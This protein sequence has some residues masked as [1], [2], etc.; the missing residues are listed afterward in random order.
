M[1]IEATYKVRLT[2]DNRQ[3]I[4]DE[5]KNAGVDFTYHSV[6]RYVHIYI[7]PN[8]CTTYL[9]V[10]TNFTEYPTVTTEKFIELIREHS[11]KLKREITGHVE[12]VP[13][14]QEEL[15]R[16]YETF[17]SAGFGETLKIPTFG[18]Y[19]K[20]LEFYVICPGQG[21]HTLTY[22]TYSAYPKNQVTLDELC[23]YI[24][25]HG[26][27]F[28]NSKAPSKENNVVN[29]AQKVSVRFKINEGEVDI[30]R[31]LLRKTKYFEGSQRYIKACKSN[32]YFYY[33]SDQSFNTA[34]Y[35]S[36]PDLKTITLPQFV[37]YIVNNILPETVHKVK[38]QN[39]D[40]EVTPNGPIKA[41]CTTFTK[42]DVEQLVKLWQT[43]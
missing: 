25:E 21:Y 13:K 12:Y 32:E 28:V 11:K 33:F 22:L 14:N 29:V 10:H 2:K 7:R 15:N 24:T 43:K 6:D 19:E 30:V 18:G 41:G 16:I 17:N 39:L 42:S 9:F 8:A 34:S 35:T 23:E 36:E 5:L 4:Q 38:L 27:K 31:G 3:L 37:E 20:Y 1:T 40:I 26:K